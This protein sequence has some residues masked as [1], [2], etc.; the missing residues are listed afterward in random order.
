MLQPAI[1][2]H[3][4]RGEACNRSWTMKVQS[5]NE[6]CFAKASAVHQEDQEYE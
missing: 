1:S 2:R 4:E 3:A 6:A 5:N